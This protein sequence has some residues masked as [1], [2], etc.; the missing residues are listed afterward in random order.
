VGTIETK[1]LIPVRWLIVGAN[2]MLGQDLALELKDSQ[3][4]TLTR[5]DCDITNMDQVRKNIS[6]ADVVINCAA[7]TAVDD[8]ESN[9]ELAFSINAQGPKNL[10]IACKEIGAK[11][12]QISTD[13]VFAG[14]ESN[15]YFEDS[16]TNP[17]SIYGKSKLAG[18]QEVQSNLPDNHL[19]VRTAWLYGKYGKNFGKTILKLAENNETLNVVDDQIGQP[20][21]SVDL[22]K[23]IVELSQVK[24][25]NGV[26]H[27]TSQGQISWFGFARE[28]FK[29][30][31]LDPD[32]LKPVSSDKFP[33]PAPRPN[34]SVL[35]HDRFAEL[36]LKPIRHWE[37]SLSA[38]HKAG[39]FNA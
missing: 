20:T 30:V 7:Y 33:R 26:F 14:N 15:P 9:P 11:L 38:A 36:N 1:D 35:G 39:V 19:I 28:L 18:E 5:N 2:G 32:R 16:E 24:N 4:K 29:L 3:L 34:Y 8:S 22:A 31:G 12:V 21:W 6:E 10:A 27:G 17:K 25:A 23:K 13:Y 37:E